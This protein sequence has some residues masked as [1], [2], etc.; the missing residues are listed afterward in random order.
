MSTDQQSMFLDAG[1]PTKTCTKCRSTYLAT[2][3]FFY[4]HK[5]GK[6]GVTPRCKK[7]VDEDNHDSYHR[8][9]AAEPD[10]VRAKGRERANKHY[11]KD[12]ERS[13][14]RMRVAAANARLDPEKRAR[15]NMRKRGAGAGMTQSAFDA[16]FESQGKKCA[17]CHASD[18]GSTKGPTNWNID[19]CHK[20]RKVRFILCCHCNRGLGA[21]RDSPEIMRRAADLLEKIIDSQ[22]EI[23]A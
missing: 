22:S 19:H 3:E 11:Y 6:Y 21:F 13:R 1:P 5:S 17:I 9:L 18:P 20:T 15:I 12:L 8:R 14:E 10:V 4:K 16:L 2:F 7:C 23:I